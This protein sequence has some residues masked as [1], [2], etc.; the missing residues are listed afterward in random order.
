MTMDAGTI[1][2]LRATLRGR[3]LTA[4]EADYED[5]R[6]VWNGMID[7]RPRLIVQAADV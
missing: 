1:A 6:H 5:A 2:R 7:K 4:D 3:V